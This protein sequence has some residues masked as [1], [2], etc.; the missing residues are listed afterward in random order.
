MLEQQTIV[1]HR[2]H[3]A[4]LMHIELLEETRAGVPERSTAEAAHE[5]HLQAMRNHLV[6]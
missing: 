3:L 4:S 5:R 1:V 2:G 6:I